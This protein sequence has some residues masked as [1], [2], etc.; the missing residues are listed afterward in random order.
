MRVA[1]I[2]ARFA[3]QHDH[4]SCGHNRVRADMTVSPQNMIVFRADMIVSARD[5]TVFAADMIVSARP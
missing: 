5:L 4:V 2:H 3:K 1:P